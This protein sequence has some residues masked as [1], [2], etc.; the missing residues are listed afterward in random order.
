MKTLIV[1]N[2][3]SEYICTIIQKNNEIEIRSEENSEHK[4]YL[5]IIK[6]A[7][8]KGIF[9]IIYD[10]NSNVGLPFSTNVEEEDFID[11]LQIYLEMH[12]CY[13]YASFV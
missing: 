5:D 12:D 7:I 10:E 9:A 6:K 11:S 1:N 2:N 13:C 8:D 3:I 4:Y